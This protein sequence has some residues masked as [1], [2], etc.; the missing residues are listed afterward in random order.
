MSSNENRISYRYIT[1]C[2]AQQTYVDVDN[3]SKGRG[4]ILVLNDAKRVLRTFY[5]TDGRK[6]GHTDNGWAGRYFT[7]YEKHSNKI[8]SDTLHA[9]NRARL[10]TLLQYVRIPIWRGGLL[11]NSHF[12]VLNRDR[13]NRREYPLKDYWSRNT[14]TVPPRRN[15]TKTERRRRERFKKKNNNISRERDP[16]RGNRTRNLY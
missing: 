7:P 11:R 16:Y 2:T 15:A 9:R 6:C 3:E 12:P 10:M 8:Q 13:C 14:P 5:D 4:A 1:Y